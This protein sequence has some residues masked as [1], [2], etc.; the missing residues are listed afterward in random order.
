MFLVILKF[1]NVYLC[2]GHIISAAFKRDSFIKVLS[3]KT[4]DALAIC[5]H[6]IENCI[7][8]RIT[9]FPLIQEQTLTFHQSIKL[10]NA[11]L[12]CIP[13]MAGFVMVT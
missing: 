3:V 8:Q 1:A 4:F 2:S 13:L 6:L 7:S 9:Y 12:F 10:L 11:H 5:F